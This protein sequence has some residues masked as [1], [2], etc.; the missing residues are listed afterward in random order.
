MD[1][2]DALGMLDTLD[3]EAWTSDGLPKIEAVKDLLGRPVTRQEI[4][5]AAPKFTR[6]NPDLGS[7]PEEEDQ[8]EDQP[9]DEREPVDF[10]EFME[11]EPKDVNTFLSF[12]DRVPTSQLQELKEGLDKQKKS[13]QDMRYKLDE[14]DRRVAGA[15]T[16]VK[17]RIQREIP[18]ISDREANQAYLESQAALRAKKKAATVQLLQGVK[19]SDLD[20][21]A[22]IDRAFARKT[23][24]GT[25]RPGS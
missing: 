15:V 17:A 11:S 23:A 13:F 8:E 20:P 21:R 9:V 18:D 7:E 2:R 14:Y 6:Q 12:L 4:V 3:N 16:M 5:D 25:Q 1:I 10:A 22:P 19:I 24:R